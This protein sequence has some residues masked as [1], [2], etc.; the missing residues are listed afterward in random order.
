MGVECVNADSRMLVARC[1]NSKKAY[2]IAQGGAGGTQ[3][4][5][6]K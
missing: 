2:L 6:Y 4:N 5:Q 3:H 1:I